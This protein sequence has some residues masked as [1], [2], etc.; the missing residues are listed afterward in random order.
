MPNL[1]GLPVGTKVIIFSGWGGSTHSE[2]YKSE[3]TEVTKGGNYRLRGSESIW[4]TRGYKRGSN[5]YSST[6]FDLFNQEVWDRICSDHLEK[7]DRRKLEG[8]DFRKLAIEKVRE[9]LTILEQPKE[10]TSE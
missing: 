1:E 6:Y 9:I 8:T 5:S 2:I 10:A 7:R 4:N 3:I